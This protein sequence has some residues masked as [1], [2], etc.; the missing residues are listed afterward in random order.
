[1][2]KR[3]S[4][5]LLNNLLGAITGGGVRVIDLT[6]TLDNIASECQRLFNLKH[7]TAM[8]QL[9]DHGGSTVHVA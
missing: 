6:M 3:K 5:G 4:N 1:M 9:G 8:I 2:S 7:D